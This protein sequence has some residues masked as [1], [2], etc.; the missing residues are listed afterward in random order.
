[1]SHQNILDKK[2]ARLS[3]YNGR[4]RL[5]KQRAYDLAC[6][7]FKKSSSPPPFV[8]SSPVIESGD[9]EW[10]VILPGKDSVRVKGSTEEKARK[11]ARTVLGLARLPAGTSVQRVG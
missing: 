9:P 4:K 6:A 7:R 11:E 2:L 10:V 8:S 5:L 3:K 1:M